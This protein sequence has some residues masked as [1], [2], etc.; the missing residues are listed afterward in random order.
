[1]YSTKFTIRKTTDSD[2]N[3]IIQLNEVEVQQT[4][5]MDLERLRYL[6]Q[7]SCYHNVAIINGQVVAFLL[8]MREG[9][10]YPNDNFNWFATRLTS[11]LYVDRIVVDSNFSGMK[12]GSSLYQN[13]FEFARMQSIKSIVCEY[14]IEPP[15]LASQ[16]FHEK[17][18]FKELG[19][20]WVAGGTKLVS[21]Q[22]SKV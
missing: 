12:I 19:T 7:L 13:M 8:A 20:Q 1:M 21:L 9:T 6:D 17:F 5:H 4:S 14:N 11:F 15:N 16:S 22:E 2:F 18:G 10:T 3:S